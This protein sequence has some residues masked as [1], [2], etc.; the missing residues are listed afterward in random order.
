VLFAVLRTE[1]DELLHSAVRRVPSAGNA[2]VARVG[3]SARPAHRA[4]KVHVHGRPHE[5]AQ[6]SLNTPRQR[7]R[8]G[9]QPGS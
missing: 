3:P 8:F 9:G 2:R 5:A 1:G 4:A 7:P 6:G